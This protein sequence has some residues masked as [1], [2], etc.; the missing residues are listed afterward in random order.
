[1]SSLNID[2]IYLIYGFAAISAILFAEGAY[3]LL[4]STTSYRKRIN[5][6]LSLLQNNANRES[7]LVQLRRERGLTASGNLSMPVESLN[8]LI[9]QSGLSIG[10]TKI[11]FI[12]IVSTLLLF[13]TLV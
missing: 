6:R 1:M 10:L 11:V 12:A 7:I 8:R 2:P 5:R 13:A 9:M 4:H 3:L